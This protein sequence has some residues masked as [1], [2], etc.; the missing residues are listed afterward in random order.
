MR[1][2]LSRILR[3]APVSLLLLALLLISMA[4]NQ[5]YTV[6]VADLCQAAHALHGEGQLAWE[7]LDELAP[8]YLE[9]DDARWSAAAATV[10]KACAAGRDP[11]VAAA[12]QTL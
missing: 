3:R 7:G 2:L 1:T 8:G 10:A 9:R 11:H 4:A 6:Q 12:R 5:R